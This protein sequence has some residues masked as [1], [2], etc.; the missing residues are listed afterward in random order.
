MYTINIRYTKVD[1]DT[2]TQVETVYN[3]ILLKRYIL[4]LNT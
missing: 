4:L 3:V 1:H 2:V